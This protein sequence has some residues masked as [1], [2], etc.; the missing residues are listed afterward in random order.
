[1]TGGTARQNDGL[2]GIE[3][4]YENAEDA[5]DAGK[6]FQSTS[7]GITRANHPW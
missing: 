7:P 5:G 1:V 4:H 6:N 3:E 2:K